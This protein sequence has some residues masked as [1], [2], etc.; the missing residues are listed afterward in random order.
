MMVVVSLEQFFSI[1][2]QRISDKLIL[3][4]GQRAIASIVSILVR[5]ASPTVSAASPWFE[6]RHKLQGRMHP[7]VVIIYYYN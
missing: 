3:M 1:C 7:P 6:D 5:Y 4:Q 2:P